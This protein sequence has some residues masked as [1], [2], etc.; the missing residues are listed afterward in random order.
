M[1][2]IWRG[3]TLSVIARLG[4]RVRFFLLSLT[5][6]PFLSP[7]TNQVH[8]PILCL[9]SHLIPPP[10]LIHSPDSFLT[11]MHATPAQALQM[12]VD[13]RARHSLAMHFATFAG[14]DHEALEPIV[15]LEQ[16]RRAMVMVTSPADR[17]GSEDEGEGEREGVVSV[18]DWWTEGGMG[19]IDVGETA[20]VHVGKTP[21]SPEPSED[22]RTVT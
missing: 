2:P 20:V 11:S 15:E 19:V 16:A 18:G 3:G 14:S 9:D 17:Q 4:F 5:S 6:Q 7:K 8:Y 22:R 1:I 21:Q 12:H 13:L 10:Q